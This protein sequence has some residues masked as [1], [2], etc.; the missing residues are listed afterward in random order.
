MCT[1][2]YGKLGQLQYFF[3]K[4]YFFGIFLE[5][6]EVLIWYFVILQTGPSDMNRSHVKKFK[7]DC[8]GMVCGSILFRI[9]SKYCSN[10][11]ILAGADYPLYLELA[12]FPI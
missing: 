2:S 7:T 9:V 6:Y 1:H 4:K 12:K 5:Y 10:K 11:C 8:I 3:S